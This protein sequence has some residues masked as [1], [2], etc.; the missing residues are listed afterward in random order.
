MDIKLDLE[1]EALLPVPLASARVLLDDLE[2][3]IG[4]FPN[5]RQLTALGPNAYRWDLRT[6]GVRVAKIAHD[7]SYGARYDI[8]TAGNR[9]RWSPIP[10]VGNAEI[11]GDIS[12][13]AASDSTTTMRFHIRGALHGVPVPLLYRPLAGPFIVNKMA[14]LIERYLAATAAALR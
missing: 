1:R 10:G 3:T 5:L 4:R 2:A 6:M 8:D 12:L 14:V 9:I 7:V 11:A 13:R